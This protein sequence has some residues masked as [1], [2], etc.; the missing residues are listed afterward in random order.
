MILLFIQEF[1]ENSSRSDALIE[2]ILRR[3]KTIKSYKNMSVRHI[4]GS[5][6]QKNMRNRL[7]IVSRKVLDPFV[8][9]RKNR[10]NLIER[11]YHCR[12]KWI[13]TFDCREI[14][15]AIMRLIQTRETFSMLYFK[16]N[17]NAF[18]WRCVR[19]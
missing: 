5:A 18:D 19:M 14:I 8:D 12:R 15:C 2:N 7:R 9:S 16:S 17:K 1:V 4:R 13:Y 10:I 3:A 6:K 11:N